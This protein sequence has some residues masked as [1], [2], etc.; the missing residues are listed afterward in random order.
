MAPI[1]I[2]GQVHRPDPG[3]DT[4]RRRG[5]RSSRGGRRQCSREVWFGPT[6]AAFV[7]RAPQSRSSVGGSRLEPFV[8]RPSRPSAP[9]RP[10][11]RRRP[12]DVLAV[13][14]SGPKG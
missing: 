9:P 5:R 4:R 2:V 8:V 11:W 3:R 14:T 10:R 13:H 1:A 6:R 7:G 12:S